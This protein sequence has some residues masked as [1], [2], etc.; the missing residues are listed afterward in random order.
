ML[1]PPES[2]G[3]QGHQVHRRPISS[4]AHRD[5]KNEPCPQSC[6]IMNMRTRNP[7][8]SIDIGNVIHSDT[9]RHRYIAVQVAKNPPN[10]VGIYPRLDANIGAEK[11]WSQKASGLVAASSHP[12]PAEVNSPAK[13]LAH[14]HRPAAAGTDITLV[15]VRRGRFTRSKIAINDM[16]V[17]IPSQAA[18]DRAFGA[19]DLFACA[20]DQHAGVPCCTRSAGSVNPSSRRAASLLV[21]ATHPT[22]FDWPRASKHVFRLPPPAFAF[23]RRP[24]LH[25]DTRRADRRPPVRRLARRHDRCRNSHPLSAPL[26][27]ETSRTFVA[28]LSMMRP[29]VHCLG[30]ARNRLLLCGEGRAR[31]VVHEYLRQAGSL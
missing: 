21:G 7:A 27:A 22:S 10:E 28:S 6:W 5:L 16:I 11:P 30:R 23:P 31:E 29:R 20:C 15:S 25:Q 2:I 13:R 9:A 19:D 4:F 26:V 17:G 12:P 18:E 24:C 3:R 8:A 1:P 14:R